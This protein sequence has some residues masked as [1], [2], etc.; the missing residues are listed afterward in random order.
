MT[1][2]IESREKTVVRSTEKLMK[3]MKQEIDDMKR[4]DDEIKQLSHTEHHIL[5]LQVVEQDSHKCLMVDILSAE[6][7]FIL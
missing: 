1:Q 2:Q 3:Q 5:F 4:Q 7:V 6:F